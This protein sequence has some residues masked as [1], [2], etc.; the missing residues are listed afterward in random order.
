MDQLQNKPNNF[1]KKVLISLI[2]TGVF[3]I[4]L[5]FAFAYFLRKL[6]HFENFYAY[7]PWI[8][9]ALCVLFLS[10]FSKSMGKDSVLISLIAASILGILFLIIGFLLGIEHKYFPLVLTRVVLFIIGSVSLTLILIHTK[11]RK[12]SSGKKFKFS[13]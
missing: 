6:P 2:S 12:R 1:L 11:R 5:C 3:F 8:L 9:V 10:I 13:K 4:V 7:V